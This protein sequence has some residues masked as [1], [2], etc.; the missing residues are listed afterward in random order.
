MAREDQ[1]FQTGTPLPNM[2]PISSRSGEVQ[3]VELSLIQDVQ[4]VWTGQRMNEDTC[5]VVKS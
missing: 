5:C 3:V 2:R 1:R 4:S